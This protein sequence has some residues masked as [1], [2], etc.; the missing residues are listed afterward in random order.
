MYLQLLQSSMS[1]VRKSS[2]KYCCCL[3]HQLSWVGSTSSPLLILKSV[4]HNYDQT[5]N[6]NHCKGLPLS[7]GYRMLSNRILW[8]TGVRTAVR[9]AI[10]GCRGILLPLFKLK[11]LHECRFCV[12]VYTSVACFWS[13]SKLI[14]ALVLVIEPKWNI[15]KK[16]STTTTSAP[17]QSVGLVTCI[18]YYSTFKA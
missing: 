2:R 7:L 12:S 10:K 15:R 16:T 18:R 5:Y 17:A 11:Y 9:T 6:G 3:S 14:T 1:N 4:E 8:A 13:S